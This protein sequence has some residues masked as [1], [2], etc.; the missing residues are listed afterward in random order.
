VP[1]VRGQGEEPMTARKTPTLKEK[2]AAEE[3]RPVVGYEGIYEVSSAGRIK[4]LPR[5]VTRRNGTT[6]PVKERIKKPY[7]CLKGGYPTIWL[8]RNGNRVNRYIHALVAEAFI[9]PRPDR[10][11]VCHADGNPTN[12]TVSNLR[13]GTRTENAA[14]AIAHDRLYRGEAHHYS[15]LTKDEVLAMRQMHA[16]GCSET[17]I[18]NRFGVSASNAHHV[19]TRKTWVHI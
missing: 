13:Y 12:N 19:V 11:D 15:R 10:H 6:V 4:T 16:D 1:E 3:W 2:L 14:D 18:A 5:T 7:I 8:Q 9:G 17:E